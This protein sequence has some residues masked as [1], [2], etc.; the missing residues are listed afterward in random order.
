MMDNAGEVYSFE[1]VEKADTI[2]RNKEDKSSKLFWFQRLHELLSQRNVKIL[3]VILGL[4]ITTMFI[5][6]YVV[7]KNYR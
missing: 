1:S 6:F 4:I 5:L 2:Q 7:K 3:A